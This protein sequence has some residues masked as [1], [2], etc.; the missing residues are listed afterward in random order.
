MS[1]NTVP[2][3]EGVLFCVALVPTLPTW[4]ARPPTQVWKVYM[5]VGYAGS[6]KSGGD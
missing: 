6:K 2:F 5:D 4:E 3:I 1:P